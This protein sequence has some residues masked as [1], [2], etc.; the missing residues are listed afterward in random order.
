MV[1][2]ITLGQFLIIVAFSFVM[3][4]VITT[5]EGRWIALG[6]SVLRAIRK[7]FIGLRDAM[8][9]YHRYTV[10]HSYHKKKMEYIEIF[11]EKGM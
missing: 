6:K 2:E 8:R 10:W 4:V 5:M 3:S 11:G 1:V 9:Q 7:A